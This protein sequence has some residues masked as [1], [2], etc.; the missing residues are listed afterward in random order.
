[1]DA[2]GNT[3]LHYLARFGCATREVES[4]L[5]LWQVV[6]ATPAA[7][8]INQANQ[9]GDTAL[10][11]VLGA[12]TPLQPFANESGV[13][14][15]VALL[16]RHG[17]S[18]DGQN[19]LGASVLHLAAQRGALKL[20]EQLLALGAPRGLRDTI[21]RDAGETALSKGYVDVAAA[22]RGST[23]TVSVARLLRQPE[24]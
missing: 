16:L 7:R 21:G 24:N 14:Q 18:L 6:L 4:T 1:M 3:V 17:A 23:A 8:L 20:V 22:L 9:R 5:R 2:Q 12:D 19:Q 15:Q 13:A 10:M 11:L